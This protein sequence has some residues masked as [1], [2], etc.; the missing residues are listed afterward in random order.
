MKL[1]SS[2]DIAL[3]GWIVLRYKI[4]QSIKIIFVKQIVGDGGGTNICCDRARV[5]NQCL[6]WCFSLIFKSQLNLPRERVDPV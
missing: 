1:S 3:Y 2:G 4:N 6:Q 5:K